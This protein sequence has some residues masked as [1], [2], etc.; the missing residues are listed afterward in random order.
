MLG[1]VE[2]RLAA[3]AP[4]VMV[5]HS[6]QGG[7]LCENAPGLRIDYSNMEIAAV[8]A[9]RP[10]LLVAATGDWTKATMTVE[11]P[12]IEKIY[13][14]FNSPEKLRYTI[15]DFDHNY[16][17]TTREAVYAFFDKW[18]L[19]GDHSEVAEVPYQKEPDEALRV[20]PDGKLPSDAL[21]E[22]QLIAALIQRAKSAWESLRPKDQQTFNHFKEAMRP[23]WRHTLAVEAPEK[24]L[25]VEPGKVQKRD[26]WSVTDLAI[27][28][29]GRGDRVPVKLVTPAK[30][31]LSWVAV[32]IAPEGTSKWCDPE[33]EL[34]GL[35]KDLAAANYAVLLVDTFGGNRNS[36][37]DFFATYNRTAVQEKVQDIITA[38][39][40]A[41]THAKGRK[42]LL[43]GEGQAGFWCT[44]AAPAADATIADCSSLE[45]L[46][47]QAALE[48]DM[49][50]PGIM[51]IRGFEGPVA[52]AA[53]QPLLLHNTGKEFEPAF[54]NDTYRS[55]KK[56]NVLKQESEKANNA[57]IVQWVSQLTRN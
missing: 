46:K 50:V 34:R 18:L 1:A 5:S 57:S 17:K 2:D 19:Q 30:D 55:L 4:I 15:F 42:V 49:F 29:A 38:C 23:A 52:L 27:G 6:M 8:P 36:L 35:A 40:F 14:L 31:S 11:G 56:E 21:N 44:L 10:Q 53:P 43:V 12:S 33:G 37:S 54:V 16:N 28:R 48:P 47:S 39:S 51:R 45:R 26:G 13:R 9:P 20:F 3:Q 7:C 32:L 25:I 41:Q 24:G 22:P